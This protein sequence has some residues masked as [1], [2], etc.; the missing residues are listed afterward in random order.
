MEGTSWLFKS[1]TE[2]K[3]MTGP[4]YLAFLGMIVPSIAVS[5]KAIES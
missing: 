5:Q 3:K 1:I 2:A 4:C